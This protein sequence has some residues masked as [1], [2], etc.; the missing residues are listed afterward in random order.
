MAGI[1]DIHKRKYVNGTRNKMA[2]NIN[3][4]I[5]MRRHKTSEHQTPRNRLKVVP[6]TIWTK[7]TQETKHSGTHRKPSAKNL[8]VPTLIFTTHQ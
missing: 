5:N 1:G 8:I 6:L 3:D 2:A 4:K 7:P